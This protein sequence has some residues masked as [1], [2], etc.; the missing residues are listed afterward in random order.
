VLLRSSAANDKSPNNYYI[1]IYCAYIT[2]I[3]INYTLYEITPDIM[4][5]LEHITV[6]S[7]S[8]VTATASHPTI[9]AL[10]W[11]D[12]GQ[13]LFLTKTAVYILVSIVFGNYFPYTTF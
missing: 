2:V 9:N 7:T 11:T 1:I 12:D 4:G 5:E 13:L 3:L 6:Y 8:S 10:Q